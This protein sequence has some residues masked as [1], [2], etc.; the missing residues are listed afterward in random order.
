MQYNDFNEF[1]KSD[2]NFSSGEISAEEKAKKR[3]ITLFNL[4][5][6][7]Y[8]AVLYIVLV[9]A[10]SFFCF[11]YLNMYA[12]LITGNEVKN[13]IFLYFLLP[14]FHL[15]VYMFF[16][17]Y[18]YR[19]MV[20]RFESYPALKYAE[21]FN[22]MTV[23]YALNQLITGALCFILFFFPLAMLPVFL[24]ALFVPNIVFALLFFMKIKDRLK[25]ETVLGS[26]MNLMLPV[27]LL[28]TANTLLNII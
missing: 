22:I 20:W 9:F 1:N 18:F 23:Y 12:V 10:D 25:T 13:F 24:T 15:A 3:K 27:L 14:L 2:G 26:F 19:R 8:F 5:K 11:S 6:W 21:F 17:G 7:A 28:T 4:P 16:A